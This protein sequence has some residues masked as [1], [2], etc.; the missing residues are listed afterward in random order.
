M[1]SPAAVRPP[2]SAPPPAPH[3]EPVATPTPI[4][5]GPAPSP[6]AL[7][8]AHRTTTA[9]F[10]AFAVGIGLWAGAIPVLMRRTGI[11][12][13]GLGLALALNSGAYIGG[14]ILSGR[15]TQRFELRRLM[16][17]LLLA[18]GLAFFAIFGASS[19]W[20]LT[21]GMVAVGLCAGALD[22]AM[23]TE[24]T[25]LERELGRPV[26]TRMHAA[27]SAGFALSAIAGSLLSTAVGAP[28]LAWLGLAVVVAV[29]W[30][31]RRLGPRAAP[32]L[33]A[34]SSAVEAPAPSA[35]ASPSPAAGRRRAHP[36]LLFGTVLGLST[37][38]EVTAQMW[39]AKF[40]AEQAADLAAL[41][42]AGAALFAGC[43]SVV[44]LFGDR[45]RQRWDDRRIIVASLGLAAAGF[46]VVAL[47]QGF[48]G[49]VA[50]FALV[51]LGT[52]CVV[53]CCF[54]LVSHAAPERSGAALAQASLV[55]GLIRLPA[56]LLIGQV[57][58]H[59]SDNVAF[60]GIAVALALG[61]L[62]L[63]LAGSRAADP[64]TPTAT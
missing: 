63:A 41:A 34:M 2:T 22:L 14:M 24:A 38:A 7:R 19:P 27:A 16:A 26:M 51:G 15:L 4:G 53:P 25:T 59:L 23:N 11:D 6:A 43:Q 20:A 39:S 31:V 54:A 35:A 36:V 37:M 29:W 61:M 21:L 32:T 50:G 64:A 48:A 62:L 18:H 47:A 28:P 57:V 13:A 45:L 44:R 56:P 46:A 3:D 42:G 8:A 10:F 52:A 5:A 9:V 55:S 33:P 40:L 30:A 58:A 12:A 1:T 49:G 60:F 17:A